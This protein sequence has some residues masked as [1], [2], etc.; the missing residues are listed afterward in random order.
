[1]LSEETLALSADL[2]E[3]AD[4]HDIFRRSDIG[5]EEI[6]ERPVYA[7]VNEGARILEEG[8]AYH[9]SDMDV[10]WTAGY[11]FPDYCGAGRGNMPTCAGWPTS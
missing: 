3:L 7:M 6:V 8:I 5:A 10:V 1:M 4:P 11:G 9:S 2:A